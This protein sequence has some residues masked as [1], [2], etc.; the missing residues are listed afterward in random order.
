[1]KKSRILPLLIAVIL[2]VGVTKYVTDQIQDKEEQKKLVEALNAELI[3]WKDKDSLSHAKIQVF[4]TQKEKD[5]LAIKSADSTVQKLQNL[6]KTY[7]KRLDEGSSVTVV[8]NETSVSDTSPTTVILP[9]SG[10]VK[11]SSKYVF[12]TYLSEFNLGGWV[13]GT[14]KANKDSTQID[15]RIRN[16]YSVIVGREKDRGWFKPSTAYVEVIN[17]N[18]Y[19]ET[20]ALRTYQVS[21]KP[22]KKWSIGPS[23]GFDYRGKPS[24]GLFVTYGLIQF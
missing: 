17:K 23:A 15:L 16:E 2:L 11:D 14:T 22:E 18:P 20:T 1:M 10:G 3:T 13:F 8:N 7:K 5:F 4:E 9:D 19:T 6:V 12:P 21:I 24:F